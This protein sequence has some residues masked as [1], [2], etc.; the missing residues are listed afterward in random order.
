MTDD[1]AERAWRSARNIT[2]ATLP[3]FVALP[4]IASLVAGPWAFVVALPVVVLGPLCLM[5]IAEV[6]VAA[7][8]A[9][10]T[11]RAPQTIK[12]LSWAS[13]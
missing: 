11:R 7:R 8:P 10:G 3:L 6:L 12:E 13:E 5:S 2:L 1:R 4:V 9:P